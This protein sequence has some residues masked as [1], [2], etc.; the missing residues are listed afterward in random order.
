[1]NWRPQL[2][3]RSL[4]AIYMLASATG[5]FS[6]AAQ[7]SPSAAK[8]PRDRL[9]FPL[10]LHDKLLAGNTAPGTAVQGKLLLATLARGT[11]IPGGT[12]FTGTVEES[13]ARSGAAPSRLRVHVTAAQWKDQ[14]LAVDLYLTNCYYPAPGQFQTAVERQEYEDALRI[15]ARTNRRSMPALGA[16]GYRRRVRLK[17][18][19]VERDEHG[20]ATITS[21][22]ATLHLYA[23]LTYCF[24]GSVVEAEKPAAK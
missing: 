12:L 17:D 10:T 8:S 13:V 9:E 11:V 7:T 5:A 20:A 14:T 23:N 24:E 1:M 18:V 19:K 4:L 15:Q 22:R 6:C 16:A 3:V 21:T 2:R